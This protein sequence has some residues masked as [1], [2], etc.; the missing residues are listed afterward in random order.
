MRQHAER[1]LFVSCSAGDN[2]THTSPRSI[3]R[4][5]LFPPIIGS[6]CNPAIRA[7]P[8]S[9]SFNCSG[10]TTSGGCFCGGLVEISAKT[11]SRERIKGLLSQSKTKWKDFKVSQIHILESIIPQGYYHFPLSFNWCGL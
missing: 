6:M 8:F 10:P 2:N 3:T 9:L 7:L 5:L 1:L 4:I 11:P